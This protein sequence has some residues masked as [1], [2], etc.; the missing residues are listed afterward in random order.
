MDKEQKKALVEAWELKSKIMKDIGTLA[1]MNE[2]LAYGCIRASE[3]MIDMIM[4]DRVRKAEGEDN[5]VPCIDESGFST[6]ARCKGGMMDW[7]LTDEEITK[8]KGSVETL[9]EDDGAVATAAV[10]KVEEWLEGGCREHGAE[11]RYGF[12]EGEFLVTRWACW[13]CRTELSEAL[14]PERSTQER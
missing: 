7:M 1:C 9:Y 10:R 11:E 8:A 6:G 4:I 3:T 14:T 12:S 2:A 13:K 5:A